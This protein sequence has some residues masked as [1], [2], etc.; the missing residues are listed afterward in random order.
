MNTALN[1][2]AQNIAA[3]APRL[4]LVAIL[5]VTALV[6]LPT[7]G[8]GYI[9]F[10]DPFVFDN[11]VLREGVSW[12]AI[13]WSFASISYYDYWHPLTWL[14]H[15]IDFELFGM[16]AGGHHF[17]NLMYHLAG[18]IAAYSAF[19]HVSRSP[20]VSVGVASL[21]ALH[22]T[23]VESVAWII[24]RKDVLSGLLYF[25]ALRSYCRFR[26]QRTPG[27]YAMLLVYFSLGLMAKPMAITLPMALLLV[28]YRFWQT[29]DGSARPSALSIRASILDKV[30]LLVLA[31]AFALFT[32][33][34]V[35]E[36][37]MLSELTPESVGGRLGNSAVAYATYLCNLFWPARQSLVYPY[38]DQLNLSA[39]LSSAL[40][41]IAI[42]ATVILLRRTQPSLLVGWLW[43]LGTLIPV[44]GLIRVGHQLTA[45][46]FLYIPAVGIYFAICA[47]I[48]SWAGRSRRRAVFIGTVAAVC[49]SVL[50]IQTAR[51]V[52][53]WSS[54]ETLYRH[55]VEGTQGNKA[56]LVNLAAALV[57]EGKLQDA[58]G[59]LREAIAVDP[60][61]L[62]A[63]TNLAH[64]EARI[65]DTRQAIRL[66][67]RALAIAPGYTNARMGLAATYARSGDDSAA[68]HH[69]LVCLEIEPHSWTTWGFAGEL[70]EYFGRIPASMS[71][72]AEAARVNPA[73]WKPHAARGLLALH[74]GSLDSASVY[75]SRALALKPPEPAPFV[76]AGICEM[77]RGQFDSAYN[78]LSAALEHS[79]GNCE[80]LGGLVYLQQLRQPKA[81][82]GAGLRREANRACTPAVVDSMLAMLGSRDL[83]TLLLSRRS[84][85]L[86][87]R[88]G[89]GGG[90][91]AP[92]CVSTRA[93]LVAPELR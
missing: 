64:I 19:R 84:E 14:S 65:G 6:Y 18:V 86:R 12:E 17:S 4:A 73:S 33:E 89:L 93:T 83:R 53:K 39:V 52:G 24:E 55:A 16:N 50:A 92:D 26:T 82:S 13:R 15:M 35:A 72:Y 11:T 80:A 90:G 78:C 43:F 69:A 27:R 76:N 67:D 10:D 75:F 29:S 22:P 81:V 23:H 79:P 49:A 25:V 62:A 40:L 45:D 38:P 88:W 58:A 87:Y 59:L 57:R 85:Q 48:V 2:L 34:T 37:G 68:A 32:Y 28:D 46:R 54:S 31:G 63:I 60:Q 56:M 71:V 36:K 42:S 3:S 30:P 20:W 8:Y 70:F 9:T 7:F 74:Y 61:Y 21:F 1:K 44:I 51:Y 5:C 91:S 66:Y 41:V 77:F 47:T